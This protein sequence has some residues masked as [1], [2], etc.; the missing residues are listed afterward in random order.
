M[1]A[2][3]GRNFVTGSGQRAYIG[4]F[5]SAGGAGI[6][7]AAV[8]PA[9]GSLT[10][11]GRTDAVPDP[12]FL[13]L[14]QDGGVLYAVSEQEEH[15]QAAAFSLRDPDAPA[16]LAPAV[17]VGGGAPTHLCLYDGHLITANYAGGSV[18]VL[19][20]DPEQAPAALRHVL[21][22]EGDGPHPE[23]QEGPHA[24]AVTPD[25]RGRTLLTVDLGTDSVRVCA[26]DPATGELRVRR[27]T[28]LRPGSGPRHLTFHP[29]GHH[30]YVVEELGAGIT[31]AAWDGETR[32]LRPTGHTQPLGEPGTDHPSEIVLAPDGRFAWVA[33]RGRDEIAVLAVSPDGGR[34]ELTG[35]TGCG[36]SWPRHLTLD[37]AGRRLYAANERSGE[38]TWFDLD[39]ATGT[40][41][42]SG[43]LP[44]AA[45]SCVV[46]R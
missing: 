30:A 23:R 26:L 24:H 22:H 41:H 37:P 31:V 25:P 45:A 15:G 10:V 16:L 8:D 11:T 43:T 12:S 4:S 46:F 5:T 6:T 32:E 27:Q 34:L 42:R 9:D 44:V 19:S 36:G 29:A 14:S 7:V 20:L 35:R 40:P 1:Q 33:V 21:R 3:R 28:A 13:A 2:Y 17:R 38:V 39:P 18:S